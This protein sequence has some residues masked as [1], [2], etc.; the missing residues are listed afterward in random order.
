MSGSN[1]QISLLLDE[2][3]IPEPAA[4]IWRII[5]SEC[6]GRERAVPMPELASR[7]GISTRAV[8]SEIEYLILEHGKRIGSSCGKVSGYYLITDEADLELVYRN[9][10]NR[11][12]GNFRIAARLKRETAIQEMMGQVSLVEQVS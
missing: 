10:M 6:P 12:L 9:R 2:A 7:L 11:A 4:A 3:P 1:P 8:Q 5:S